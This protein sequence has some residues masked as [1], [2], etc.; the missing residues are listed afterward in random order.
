MSEKIQEQQLVQQ[1]PAAYRSGF[2]AIVGRP[3]AGKSTLINALVGEKIAITANQPETTRKVIRGIVS[4]ES[5][6]LVLVDTP[7]LHRPRTL[8]GQRLNDL[9][10]D[11]LSDVDAVA[12]CLPADEKIGP[13]DRFLLEKVAKLDAP[14][15]A[16]IT[17]IDKISREE[18]AQKLLAVSEIFEFAQIVPVSAQKGEQIKLLEQLMIQ[19]MPLSPPLYPDSAVTDESVESRIAELIREAALDGVRDELPHSIAVVIED[20]EE[21]PMRKG[22]SRTALIDIRANIYVERDSQKGIV[23][24]RGGQRLKQVG[25]KARQGIEELLGRKV[26]LD[27]RVKVA[28]EWQKDPKFLGRLGF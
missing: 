17:K 5:G 6:Q 19:Q 25:V 11:A 21:R 26:Y 2:V 1:W 23:I 18:L 27:M 16:V 22:D 10:A 20:F 14:I 15:F 9:V 12:L 4:R 13:G 7:G 3:N 8:L 28:K 24:G